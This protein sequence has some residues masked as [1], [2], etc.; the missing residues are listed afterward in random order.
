MSH[1]ARRVSGA[2]RGMC[3]SPLTSLTCGAETMA[4]TSRCSFCSTVEVR[5][6]RLNSLKEIARDIR[7]FREQAQ[8]VSIGVYVSY[9][10][11]S[12]VTK[13]ESA[14]K[15]NAYTF[16]RSII[17]QESSKRIHLWIHNF[18]RRKAK[19][20]DEAEQYVREDPGFDQLGCHPPH[21][22]GLDQEQ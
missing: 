11:Q 22:S 8:S 4:S 3:F 9:A 16:R 7:P 19:G 17:F 13:N 12:A 18:G 21:H 5:R 15:M 6:N 10:A 1:I 2:P 20:Q 14:V